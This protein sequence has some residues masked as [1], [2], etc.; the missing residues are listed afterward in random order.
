MTK[1]ARLRQL[2]RWL[3]AVVPGPKP[4]RLTFVRKSGGDSGRA[5]YVPGDPEV[6]LLVNTFHSQCECV[7]TLFEEHAHAQ[8]MVTGSDRHTERWGAAYQKIRELYDDRGGRS[9]SRSY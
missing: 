5:T 9:G 4:T 2:H 1:R 3:E 8:V 7:H 6:V